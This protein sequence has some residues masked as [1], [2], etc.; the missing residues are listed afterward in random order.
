[1]DWKSHTA[2]DTQMAAEL[3]ANRRSGGYL[4][5]KDFLERVQERRDGMWEFKGR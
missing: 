1:M 4:Q 2:A 3:D 5:K